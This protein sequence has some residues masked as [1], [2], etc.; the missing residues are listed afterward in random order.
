MWCFHP[1][2]S[3]L[4]GKKGPFAF[5]VFDFSSLVVFVELLHYCVSGDGEKCGRKLVLVLGVLSY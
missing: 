5:D 1:L 3:F 4:S 2:P